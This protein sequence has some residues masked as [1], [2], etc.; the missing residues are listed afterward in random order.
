MSLLD[1]ASILLTPTAYDTSKLL[2]IKPDDGGGDF[3]F[4]RPS[5]AE[6]INDSGGFETMASNVPRIDYTGGTAS[7]LLEPRT[8]NLYLNSA[9]LTTQDCS[10][11][12]V[13]H[14]SEYTV[15]F[16]GTGSITFSGSYSGSLSGTGTN[17]RV[18][19]TFTVSGSVLTST[20]SGTVTNAQ[21]ESNPAAS[22]YIPTTSSTVTRR[23]EQCIDAGD[24]SLISGTEGVL[25]AEFAVSNLFDQ[26]INQKHERCIGMGFV[27]GFNNILYMSVTPSNNF[28]FFFRVGS[29]FVVN[30]Q[31]ISA[32]VGQYYKVAFKYKSGDTSIYIDGQE[33]LTSSTAFTISQTIGNLAFN[34][35][36]PSFPLNKFQG[37]TKCV[38]VFKEALT[39]AELIC[40]TS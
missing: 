31:T 12:A 37:N 2:S 34:A 4:S 35:G 36:T 26:N 5:S 33:V 9:T 19:L 16:Y 17:D 15:S 7:F 13:Q 24:S 27:S 32:N 11:P 40:L 20:V 8:T 21:L 38:A 29:T 39:D 30:N 22:T 1:K 14:G 25:Y 10:T 6:R 23:E 18:S 28:R 3:D